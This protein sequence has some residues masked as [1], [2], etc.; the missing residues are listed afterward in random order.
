[1]CIRDSSHIFEDLVEQQTSLTA[2][3]ES[4]SQLE[5]SQYLLYLLGEMCIRDSPITA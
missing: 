4:H 3:M 2:A 5:E 1:M